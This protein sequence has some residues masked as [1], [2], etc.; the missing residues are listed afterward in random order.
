MVCMLVHVLGLWCAYAWTRCACARTVLTVLVQDANML[1]SQ[2]QWD[3]SKIDDD[4]KSR[5]RVKGDKSNERSQVKE[6]QLKSTQIY[7]NLMAG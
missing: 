7:L 5:R 6:P 2:E 3:L 4:H 1:R